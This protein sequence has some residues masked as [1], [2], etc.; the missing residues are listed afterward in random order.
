MTPYS[1]TRPQWVKHIFSRLHRIHVSLIIYTTLKMPHP[2]HRI[3]FQHV[4][5]NVTICKHVNMSTYIWYI[6]QNQFRVTVE[7]NNFLNVFIAT[8]TAYPQNMHVNLLCFLFLWLWYYGLIYS[9]MQ[10]PWLLKWHRSCVHSL[11]LSDAMWRQRTRST[12]AQVMACCLNAPSHYLNQCWLIIPKVQ[13]L[14]SEGN[15]TRNT[16]AINH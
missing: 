1:I 15:L 16:S 5:E 10:L 8:N 4:L 9:L 11:R 14:S 13:W 2:C 12:L 7:M 3:P 6:N